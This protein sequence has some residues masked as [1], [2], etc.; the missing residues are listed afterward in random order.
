MNADFMMQRPMRPQSAHKPSRQRQKPDLSCA[1]ANGMEKGRR[2]AAV[3][4]LA[5]AYF[6][7]DSIL[8]GSLAIMASVSAVLTAAVSAVLLYK[9]G[10]A[11]HAHHLMLLAAVLLCG[12]GMS[13]VSSGVTK[14]AALFS[15]LILLL[16]WCYLVCRPSQKGD[17]NVYAFC[18][19]I[20]AWFVM[21]FAGFSGLIAALFCPDR[22]KREKN[23]HP[24]LWT[25][26]GL[27]VAIPITVAAA[28]LLLRGD[29]L[30]NKIMKVIL[31]DWWRYLKDF[32]LSVLVAVPFASALYSALDVNLSSY[33]P[34]EEIAQKTYTGIRVLR[35]C[36]HAAGAWG[37]HSALRAVSSLFRRTGRLFPFG[38]P[39]LSAGRLYLCRVCK[40]R[41]F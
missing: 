28:W 23:G 26:V 34:R 8:H 17:G 9:N 38:F 24:V 12:A 25:L 37:D 41:L 39:Q 31:E 5:A 11:F 1:V 30:F 13:I 15:F 33:F 10:A 19:T 35:C 29:E 21:P 18:D 20:F 36:P 7:V 3:C 2:I 22:K 6:G 14:L 32:L 27:L 40:T 4:C 16:S